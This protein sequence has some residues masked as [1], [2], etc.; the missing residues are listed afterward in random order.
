MPPSGGRTVAVAG[1][2]AVAAALAV[3]YYLRRRR[4]PCVRR[5]AFDAEIKDALLTR[6]LDGENDFMKWAFDMFAKEPRWSLYRCDLDGIAVGIFMAFDQGRGEAFLN[7]LRTDAAVWGLGGVR[8]AQLSVA[9][10]GQPGRAAASR[11]RGQAG[12]R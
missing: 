5:A 11:Y 10:R 12:A 2:V 8:S 7:G 1:G 3:Y 4:T 6:M 9:G